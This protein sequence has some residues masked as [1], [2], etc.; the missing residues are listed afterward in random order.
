MCVEYLV[1][2]GYRWECIW[3]SLRWYSPY[4]TYDDTLRIQLFFCCGY[5]ERRFPPHRNHFWVAHQRR[6]PSFHGWPIVSL[7]FA[8]F[9]ISPLH[10]H[11]IHRQLHLHSRLESNLYF[12]QQ[13][14][15]HDRFCWKPFNYFA[16]YPSEIRCC[17]VTAIYLG[18]IFV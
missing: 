1:E 3:C 6:R 11:P 15:R 2:T 10:L 8:F 5:L 17:P 18:Y 14:D 7:S 9:S 13:R 12:N 4:L 16:Y